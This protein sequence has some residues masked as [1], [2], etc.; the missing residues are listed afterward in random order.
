MEK[1]FKAGIAFTHTQEGKRHKRERKENINEV[2]GLVEVGDPHVWGNSEPDKKGGENLH[3]NE[4]GGDAAIMFAGHVKHHGSADNGGNTVH[5]S[6]EIKER[7]FWEGNKEAAGGKHHEREEHAVEIEAEAFHL[8]CP[9]NARK[10]GGGE[11][12]EEG[13]EKPHFGINF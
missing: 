2:G 8:I 6:R 13:E 9:V 3:G 4:H 5:N 10:N 1:Q 12:K 11:A 7:F